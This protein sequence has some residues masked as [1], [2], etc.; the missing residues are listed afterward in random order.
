MP[1]CFRGP[2][3]G[4]YYGPSRSPAYEWHDRPD[5]VIPR[6]CAHTTSRCGQRLPEANPP[7]HLAGGIA[8]VQKEEVSPRAGQTRISIWVQ[9]SWDMVSSV[10]AIEQIHFVYPCIKINHLCKFSGTGGYFRSFAGRFENWH[11]ICKLFFS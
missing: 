6:L 9:Y 10:V 4:Q 11:T 1:L 2:A 8:A 7:P 5:R 3:C